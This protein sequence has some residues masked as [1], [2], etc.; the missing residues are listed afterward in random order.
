MTTLFDGVAGLLTDV[1][2]GSVTHRPAQGGEFIRHWIFRAP[3]VEVLGDDGHPVLDV[4]PIL[5]VP[6]PAAMS[7]SIGD[8]VLPGNGK[9]YAVINRQPSGSPA[10]D[11]FVVFELEAVE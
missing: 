9:I 8:R 3:P 11:A 10:S 2:G 7:V 1:F 4:L 5:R 6:G